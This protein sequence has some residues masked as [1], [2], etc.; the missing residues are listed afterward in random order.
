MLNSNKKKLVE[1]EQNT[2]FLY[3]ITKKAIPILW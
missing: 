1:E 3:K 2:Y